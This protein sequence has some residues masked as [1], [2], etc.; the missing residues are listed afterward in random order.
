MTSKSQTTKLGWAD[1][2]LRRACFIG[3]G[4]GVPLG[5]VALPFIL[6]AL[7]ATMEFHW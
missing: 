4:L 5:W 1:R 2:D 3:I 7:G 6:W